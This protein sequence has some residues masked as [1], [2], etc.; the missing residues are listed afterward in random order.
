MSSSASAIGVPLPRADGV[1]R[2]DLSPS[3]SDSS[4]P[5]ATSPRTAPRP[6]PTSRGGAFFCIERAP[7][8]TALGV[9]PV[10]AER[11]GR[12]PEALPAAAT[13]HDVH[14]PVRGARGQTALPREVPRGS[15]AP[16][17]RRA[18]WLGG[19]CPS[20]PLPRPPPETPAFLSVGS[21]SRTGSTGA[22]SDPTASAALSAIWAR[23][24]PACRR[25]RRNPPG[26]PKSP[27]TPSS[28]KAGAYPCSARSALFVAGRLDADVHPA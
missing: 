1:P 7:E 25:P 2:A 13:A 8:T 21:R 9:A 4:P 3:S 15:R 12:V 14:G 17:P 10:A 18:G 27:E 23:A 19:T 16:K 6:G 22:P 28:E 20:E 11:I 26:L 24:V 5:S